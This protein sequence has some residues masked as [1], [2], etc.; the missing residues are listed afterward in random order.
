MAKLSVVVPIYNVELYLEECLDSLKNQTLTDL[1]VI[2]V[3]DGS[4]DGSPEI[5]KRFANEDSRFQYHRI[6][7]GGL[8]HARNYGTKIATGDYIAFLDSDDL[9]PLS[10]YEE[11]CRLAEENECDFVTGGVTRFNSKKRSVSGL[12]RKALTKVKSITNLNESPSLIY[13]TTSTNKIYRR[14]FFLEKCPRFPEGILYEDIPVVVPAYCQASKVGCLKR[15][16]YLWRTREQGDS[17]ITQRRTEI[18]NLADRLKVMGMVDDYFT[19][20]VQSDELN[21]IKNI[22]WLDLD[23]KLYVNQ[24]SKADEEYLEYAMP[25]IRE[26]LESI[27][28]RAFDYVDAADRMKYFFIMKNDLAGVK[29]VLKYQ[30]RG[31]KTLKVRKEAGGF[32]GRFPIA[33]VPHNLMKMDYEIRERGLYTRVDS[34]QTHDGKTTIRGEVSPSRLNV[35]SLSGVSLDAYLVDDCGNRLRHLDARVTASRAPRKIRVSRTYRKVLLRNLKYRTFEI[36]FPTSFLGGLSDGAYNIELDYSLDGF[37]FASNLLNKKSKSCL[38]T[39][40]AVKSGGKKVSVSYDFTGALVFNISAITCEAVD[41]TGDDSGLLTIRL[42]NGEEICVRPDDEYTATP[43][44]YFESN[45]RFV[46]KGDSWTRAEENQG[47]N[48]VL[49]KV[50]PSPLL[51]SYEVAGPVVSL[52][53]DFSRVNSESEAEFD[54]FFRGRRFGAISHFRRTSLA[55]DKGIAQYSF[56]FGSESS[57]K[58]LRRDIYDVIC[59]DG[60]TEYGILSTLESNRPQVRVCA[61]NYKYFLR[62]SSPYL[63]VSAEPQFE[64]YENT[65]LK[66]KVI[67]TFGYPLLRLLPIKKKTVVFESSWGDK[68]DCN[69]GALYNYIQEHDP[70]FTCYWLLNDPR[71]PFSGNGTA[72]RFNSLQYFRVMATS[73]FFINNANFPDSYVKRKGQVEIQTMH[74]TPLKTLGLDVP[75][76][77]DDPDKRR[78]FI[79]R[80]SRWDYLIVQSPTAETIT[81]SCYAYKKAYLNTGYPRNDALFSSN[82]ADIS[83]LK[84]KY[85]IPENKK[86]IIY[87]PT[88][89]VRNVFDLRLDVSNLLDACGDEYCLGLRV[90]QFALKGLNANDLDDR[91]INL[92]NAESMEELYLLADIMIT[93]YSSLMFDF[94]ILGKPMLFY[95][96]DLEEYRDE[97]RGFN[98]DF[99]REAPGPLLKTTEDVIDAITHIDETTKQYKSAYD[100]FRNKFCTYEKGTASQEVFDSVLKQ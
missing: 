86:V 81:R 10:A 78:A 100:A 16:V 79:R 32:F 26:V 62:V 42:S 38:A 95:V 75:G 63:S 46:F 36:A 20:Y 69:P 28:E 99:E 9:I 6:P 11:M 41:I 70:S 29:E 71:T 37:S 34:L 45:P 14:D 39:P 50:S 1:E 3:D 47:G 2:L 17:S 52:C 23:L 8:G 80:C 5:A 88:W 55:A 48:L 91:V 94:A 30:R 57:V 90:H 89:R 31:M 27:D 18:K 51:T 25:A 19:K 96:Y 49:R 4:T 93:D 60:V 97:L 24:F 12:H 74:G 15:A 13:D 22:K 98:L 73:K 58:P 21:L 43:Y 54:V 65:K 76:E 66:R 85:G 84:Q 61:L 68:T 35:P 83:A 7:N 72:V 77:L 92:S 59:T 33:G 56:D 40:L 44:D 67:E 53:L 64:K 87:A 82:S